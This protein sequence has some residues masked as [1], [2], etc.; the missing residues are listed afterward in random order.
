MQDALIN[1]GALY[2]VIFMDQEMPVMNGFDAT[3][4]I[5]NFLNESQIERERQTKIV[6]CSANEVE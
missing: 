6:I 4:K 5:C 3:M 2:D 1:K